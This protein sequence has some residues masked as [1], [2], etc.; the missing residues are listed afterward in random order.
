MTVAGNAIGLE[1]GAATTA[2]PRRV[3][4]EMVGFMM[5]VA[6]VCHFNRISITTA[7][8]ARIMEQYGIEPEWMGWIYSAYLITYTVCM[9]P[10][11]WVIDRIG[12]VRALAIVLAGSVPFVAATG[13][14]GLVARDASFAFVAMWIVRAL[15]GIVSAPLHPACARVVGNWVEAGGRVRAN[16]LV[17]GSALMGIAATPPVF[18]FLITRFDWPAAFLIASGVTAAVAV[19]WMLVA[20]ESPGPAAKAT[21]S[22]GVPRPIDELTAAVDQPG[23]PAPWI[24]LLRD[25]SLI[26]LTLSFA[27]VGYF[28]YLFFYWME[29]YFEK[30][31]HLEESTSRFYVAIPTLAM[32]VGMVL[33][34]WLSDAL[35]RAH[36]V[37]WGRRFVPMGGMAAG[38]CLLGLGVWAREPVWIVTWF[39]MAMAAV[40]AAEGP[41]WATAIELGGR[42]GGSAAGLLNTGGNVGGILAPIV[43]PWVGQRYGWGGAVA[44]G[45]L[46]SLMGVALW[47]GI[48]PARKPR[49]PSPM[50]EALDWEIDPGA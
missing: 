47:F 4:W 26:L 16:G 23:T 28:Q 37:R 21:D 32:G 50:A 40:G 11:G 22:S 45:S 1:A 20:S 34:G 15:L 7:G 30:V 8:N 43:T 46:V 29:Y 31:L 38:A 9:I 12:A 36:G 25:R 18:G 44:L 5:V 24:S 10:G 27:A 39:A 33:G 17:T 13:A 48:D 41:F 3:A 49:E 14:V 19:V 35:E 2:A 6:A 42:R